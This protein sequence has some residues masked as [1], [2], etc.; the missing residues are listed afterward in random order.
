MTAI[1]DHPLRYPLTNE[2]HARPF[3][4][5]GVPGTAVF[6]AIKPAENAAARDRAADFH[7]LTKLLWLDYYIFQSILK[8]YDYSSQELFSEIYHY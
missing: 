3:P 5:L 7:H 1:A 2:L 4:T 8:H 6:I